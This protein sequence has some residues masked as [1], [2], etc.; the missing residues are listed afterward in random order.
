MVSVPPCHGGGRGF[1]SRQGRSKRRALSYERAFRLDRG[2]LAF[3]RTPQGSV[4]QLVERTTENREVT[5][6]TPVGATRT[7][8]TTVPETLA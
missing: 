6:S 2:R 7:V 8:V 3:E 4:A 1:K 5:G